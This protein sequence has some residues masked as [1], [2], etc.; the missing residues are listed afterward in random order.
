MLLK[1]KAAI[2]TGATR[3]IGRAIALELAKEG[4]DIAFTFLKSSQEAETLCGEIE[5]TGRKALALQVDGRDFDKTKEMVE[6]VK[7]AFG[8]LDILVNNAGITRDK[9]LMMMTKDDWQEVIDTNLTGT[10]N[11]TRNVIVGFLKQKSGNIVNITSVSGV[12]GLARQTN[13]AASKA[14]II[15]FTKSLAKEVAAYNI[16]V[17]AVA[18]GFIETDMLSSLKE[19]Y[20]NELKAKVPLG[21]F[22]N[23]TE[24]AAAVKFLLSDASGFITG[25]TIVIDGGLFIQ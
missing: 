12:A 9:A 22:G 11:V 17:N 7:Q 2:V 10:F 19:E 5:K 24:V 8:R 23:P 13:Y 3:G 25:Q 18:P 21:R 14:G 6:K 1:D 16:R 20:K 4:A 15:G